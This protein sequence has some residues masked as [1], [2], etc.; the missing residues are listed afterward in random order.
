[1]QDCFWKP[2]WSLLLR[3]ELLEKE[4]PVPHLGRRDPLRS[5]AGEGG[6]GPRE[7]HGGVD[8]GSR[9]DPEE[10]RETYRYRATETGKSQSHRETWREG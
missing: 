3:D 1:M 9:E 2:H 6:R 8:G 5:Q 10:E 4:G 7:C